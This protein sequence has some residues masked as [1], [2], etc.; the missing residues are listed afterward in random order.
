MMTWG[1]AVWLIAIFATLNAFFNWTSTAAALLCL[2]LLGV[3]WARYTD[4]RRGFVDKLGLEL[5]HIVATFV[6]GVVSALL[7][8]TAAEVYLGYLHSCSSDFSDTWT[9]RFCI[10][11]YG[12]Y[13]GRE[14][15]S[16]AFGERFAIGTINF[17][18]EFAHELEAFVFVPLLFAVACAVSYI[19][20][21]RR[22]AA[23]ARG[24]QVQAAVAPD[25]A[26][27]EHG[28]KE[29][30]KNPDRSLWFANGALLVFCL[31]GFGGGVVE[32]DRES[33]AASV[34]MLNAKIKMTNEL[35]D[36]RQEVSKRTR[37]IQRLQYLLASNSNND[38][39]RAKFQKTV[40]D[41]A[42]S[43]GELNSEIEKA[44]KLGATDTDLEEFQPDKLAR[45]KPPPEYKPVEVIDLGDDRNQHRR[46]A[47]PVV[48]GRVRD[49][50]GALASYRKVTSDVKAYNEQDLPTYTRA[51]EEVRYVVYTKFDKRDALV[52]GNLVLW[53]GLR[54]SETGAE[55]LNVLTQADNRFRNARDQVACLNL[56]LAFGQWLQTDQGKAG[57]GNVLA[58][59]VTTPT[60]F[61]E[62]PEFSGAVTREFA[63]V[64]P[65]QTERFN[66][67][68]RTHRGWEEQV[69]QLMIQQRA[70]FGQP[71]EGFNL[72]ATPTLGRLLAGACASGMNIGDLESHVSAL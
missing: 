5:W 64:Q 34:A 33:Y 16:Y 17:F 38:S 7:L 32:G 24:G 69:Q 15:G 46:R 22:K 41:V 63:A 1:R 20:Y 4:L 53:A 72:S 62:T 36:L 68:L 56:I 35:G 54:E 42:R 14:P 21:L 39:A 27:A 71:V 49:L 6:V 65:G 60:G 9:Y 11:D 47:V 19:S 50:S 31:F 55:I 13:Y 8:I 43:I 12:P 26:P 28:W 40:S 51:Q 29:W 2:A 3:A 52:L 18:Y 48:N 58:K 59:Y 30:F 66:E 25:A 37:E 45:T 23:Q 61:V 57:L 10:Y 70:R 44:R 67:L